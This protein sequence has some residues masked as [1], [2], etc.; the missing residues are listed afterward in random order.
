[1]VEVLGG[2]V[3]RDLQAPKELKAF[4]KIGSRPARP[5]LSTSR[6]PPRSLPP[7]TQLAYYEADGWIVEPAATEVIFGR[8]SLHDQAYRP[9]P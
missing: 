3:D 8:N 2:L 4:S 6:I 7:P 1:M 5:A 9:P